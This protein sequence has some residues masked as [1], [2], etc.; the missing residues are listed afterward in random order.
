MLARKTK[1]WFFG[2]LAVLFFCGF[3]F[4]LTVNYRSIGTNTDILYEYGNASIDI[5]TTTVTFG[6]GASLPGPTVVGAVGAGD[7]LVIGGETFY[8]L[9]RVSATEATV[10]SA[11]SSTHSNA[12]YTIKRAYNDIQIWENARDGNLSSNQYRE[13]GVCYKDGVFM[14]TSTTTIDGSTTDATHYMLL[15]VATGQQHNG[16]AGSGVVVD[17]SNIPALGSHLFWVRD[18]YF[19]ME[20]LEIRNYPGDTAN[21]QPINLDE[22]DAG[23]NLLSKLIIHDYTS[24][25]R[26]AINVY[27]SATVRNCIIYTGDKGI[28]SY[29][30]DNLTLTIE[31]VT[32]YGMNRGVD[33]QAGKLIVKNTIS[34]GSSDNRDFDLDN[35][36]PVD[37]SSGYNMYSYV[38]N[39]IHPGASSGLISISFDE[40]SKTITRST[41]SFLTDGFVI[42]NIINTD[43]GSNPGP[44]TITNVTA[45]VITVSE[46]VTTVA[47]ASRN[48]YLDV[49]SVIRQSPPASLA[50]LFI[51]ISGS[52]DLHIKPSGHNALDNGQDLSG[53][54]TD[55]IDG[56]TRPQGSGWDIGAD[57][58]GA[59]VV[60]L[61]S[62]TATGQSAS[63]LVEWA[64]ATELDNE[65]FNILRREREDGEYVKINPY[66]IPAKGAAGFGADYSYTDYDVEN[67]VTYYYLLEDVD[68]YGKSTFHGPVF[69]TP[70]DIILI[71]PIYWEVLPSGSSLFSWTSS[72]DF[73]FKV[74]VSSNPSFSDS[75]TISFPEEGWTSSISIWLRPEEWEMILKRAHASGEHLFWRVKAKSQ[76]GQ[77]VCSDWKRFI[78]EKNRLPEE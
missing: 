28:R 66:L 44:F 42:G 72:G 25:G 20:L 2:L 71:W 3:A 7:E 32:I 34:V 37:G 12:S 36:N 57:E 77:V 30:N 61:I 55:D 39:D 67:G 58:S 17:G 64:T 43:S 45:L 18:T 14:P 51:S 4:G 47:A 41:G 46:A 8:I 60:D 59:T 62:F 6:G 26:G 19:R 21:G 9:S 56:G 65:G 74:D 73:S 33:H 38:H 48:V 5:G 50:D 52:V 69:A 75:E 13:V 78:V 23:N 10:Q 63:V 53:S 35:D 40:A 68:F 27:E 11:A 31:N 15:T 54:F 24:T 76:D 29:S 22:G 16:T 70:N 1:I 49:A